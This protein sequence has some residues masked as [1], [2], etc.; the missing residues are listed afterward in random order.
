MGG[1][2]GDS[3]PVVEGVLAAEGWAGEDVYS[4]AAGAFGVRRRRL[5]CGELDPEG[6]ATGGDDRS[7]VGQL[8]GEELEGELAR[9]AQVARR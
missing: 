9:D 3:K 1:G 8:L 4:G 6:C 2:K 7:P 5:A